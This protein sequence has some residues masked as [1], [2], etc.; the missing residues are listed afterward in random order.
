MRKST[1]Y[2][3]FTIIIFVGII[4]GIFFTTKTIRTRI[5]DKLVGNYAV[6]EQEIAKNVART[7]ESDI[8]STAHVLTLMGEDPIIRDGASSTCTTA[9]RTKLALVDSQLG[10]VGRVDKDGIFRCSLNAALIGTPAKKLGTYITTIFEDPAHAP[11]MSPAIKPPGASGYLVAVHIPVWKDGVFDGTLGG[12]IYLQ[13]LQKKY[14]EDVVFVKRGFVRIIDA[15][16]TILYHQRQELIGKNIDS[17]SFHKYV[18]DSAPFHEM[19]ADVLAGKSGTK[20][21]FNVTEGEK[22]AGY[23]PAHVIGGRTWLVIVTIPIKDVTS[24]LSVLGIDSLLTSIWVLFSLMILITWVTVFFLSQKLVF[25]PFQTI[26]RMKTDFVSMVSHQLKTPMAQVMG[27]VDNM[28]DGLTGPLTPTQREYLPDIR[29]VAEDNASLI[30]DLLNV[31]RLDRG[32]LDVHIEACDLRDI[33]TNTLLPLKAFAEKQGVTIVYVPPALGEFI[34]SADKAKGVEVVRNVVHNA[35]K[36][37]PSGSK[38]EVSCK[39]DGGKFGVSVVDHGEGIAKEAE[40]LIFSREKVMGGRVRASGAGLGL[41][42][43]KQFMEKMGGDI[44]YVTTLGEGTVFTIV[45][46]KN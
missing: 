16:G 34:V 9:I 8:N 46:K 12:A 29:K 24:D 14:L 37:S 6:E 27:F 5:D 42:L 30:N 35:I 15:D 10:N 38:V 19:L 17:E 45:F 11:V 4:V 41:Y 32:I 43:A 7:L 18:G 40:S 28:L 13:D 44:Y 33:V 21:Y 26:Q 20:E 25:G 36:F 1:I 3:I 31:S 22:V 2:H 23:Y 39:E